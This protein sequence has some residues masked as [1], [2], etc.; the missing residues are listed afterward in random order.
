MAMVNTTQYVYLESVTTA[1]ELNVTN[2]GALTA[3]QISTQTVLSILAIILNCLVIWVI[4]GSRLKEVL[5][6]YFLLNLSVVGVIIGSL[7]IPAQL[8]ADSAILPVHVGTPFCV[9]VHTLVLVVNSALVL[10]LFAIAVERLIA[11][12]APLHYL[13]LVTAPIITRCI[14]GIWVI[15]LLLGVYPLVERFLHPVDLPICGFNHAIPSVYAS[16]YLL[17]N[18]IIFIIIAILYVNILIVARQQAKKIYVTERSHQVGDANIVQTE[19]V[20]LSK[21]TKVTLFLGLVVGI[22]FVCAVPI[23]IALFIRI[24]FGYYNSIFMISAIGLAFSINAVNPVIYAFAYKD[25]RQNLY[26][27]VFRKSNQQADHSSVNLGFSNSTEG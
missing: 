7:I 16:I 8:V 14:S 4:L 17:N 20:R 19:H 23:S 22:N 25:F 6:N 5:S 15:S 13:R 3:G 12:L 9:V 24:W 27:K 18:L 1:E 21:E 2:V 26:R 10:T 11:V